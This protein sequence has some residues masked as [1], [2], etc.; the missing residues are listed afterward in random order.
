MFIPT[1]PKVM[2]LDPV[3]FPHICPHY[4]MTDDLKIQSSP[5]KSESWNVELIVIKLISVKKKN[6]RNRSAG[7]KSNIRV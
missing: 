4:S 1:P 6:E 5:C 2:C 3:R 7:H